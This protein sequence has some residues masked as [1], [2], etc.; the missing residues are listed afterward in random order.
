ML[1]TALSWTGTAL[2]LVGAFLLAER[3]TAPK[4]A[5]WFML[6]GA[7][8]WAAVGL[9]RQDPAMYVLMIAYCAINI[10]GLTRWGR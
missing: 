2:Q 6:P 10:R 5:Y 9:L 3:W 8:C 1:I 4:L 7:V